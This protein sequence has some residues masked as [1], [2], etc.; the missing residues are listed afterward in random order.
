MSGIIITLVSKDGGRA[1]VEEGDASHAH[2]IA[3]GW[4]PEAKAKG[5]KQPDP[6]T[7]PPPNETAA[8][9]K[10]READEKAAADAEAKA[11]GEK[12][13]DGSSDPDAPPGK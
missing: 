8:Q 10:K 9:R 6:K 2:F 12:Q 13:P 3:K 7:T 5:E 4:T 1:I 11:K